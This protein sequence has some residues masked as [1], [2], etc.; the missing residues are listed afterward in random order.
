MD[1]VLVL[2]KETIV[3]ANEH[4]DAK[5][6]QPVTEKVTRYK[7]STE[8][9]ELTD[10]KTLPDAGGNLSLS[11][12]RFTL[13]SVAEHGQ[14]RRTLPNP[15]L[16]THWT[17]F[18]WYLNERNQP[19]VELYQEPVTIEVLSGYAATLG[20]KLEPI[21][22]AGTI[23]QGSAPLETLVQ[24]KAHIVDALCRAAVAKAS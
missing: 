3:T 4:V 17:E 7:E 24:T 1:A 20:Y 2:H 16:S 23:V 5:T 8:R 22:P 19:V 18:K 21:Q 13:P 14:F 9:V 10:R 11:R 12:M 6:G 15:K